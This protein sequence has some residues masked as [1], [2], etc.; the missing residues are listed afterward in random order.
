MY[1]H[2]LKN[3]FMYFCLLDD[4]SMHLTKFISNQMDIYLLFYK[5]HE[6]LDM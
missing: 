3:K 1:T 2:F 6:F 5:I 4:N